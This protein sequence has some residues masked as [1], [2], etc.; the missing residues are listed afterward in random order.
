MVESFWIPLDLNV[1]YK[2][3]I[4]DSDIR[5]GSITYTLLGRLPTRCDCYGVHAPQGHY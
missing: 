4:P 1:L 3:P 5:A 2:H